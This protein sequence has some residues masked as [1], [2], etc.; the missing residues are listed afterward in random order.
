MA[1]VFDKDKKQTVD[2]D[3]GASITEFDFMS[4]TERFLLIKDGETFLLTVV[5]DGDRETQEEIYSVSY[6]S[7]VNDTAKLVKMPGRMSTRSFEDVDYRHYKTLIEDLLFVLATKGN[8]NWPSKVSIEFSHIE[9]LQ[10]QNGV[11]Q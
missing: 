3:S 9:T 6:F 1:L 4:D 2:T 5:V 11:F 7:K 10:K 8:P